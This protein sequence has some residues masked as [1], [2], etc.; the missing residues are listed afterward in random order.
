[1]PKHLVSE[2]RSRFASAI[3]QSP[4]AAL[5]LG[6]GIA[7]LAG[8]PARAQN[9]GKLAAVDI[10]EVLRESE[11][12]KAA[13]ARLEDAKKKKQTFLDSKQKELEDLQK[14]Y[15]TAPLS[16]TKRDELETKI[17]ALIKDVNRFKEDAR[18]ELEK[19]EEA[20]LKKLQE[21]VLPL[22]DEIGAKEG[23]A[24]IFVKYQ[25]GLIYLDSSLDLTKTLILRYDAARKAGTL[26]KPK[27]DADD[28]KGLA[29]KA[30]PKSK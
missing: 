16:D 17:Q 22:I 26:P 10:Q 29:P 28:G 19:A 6:L 14:Q 12:G 27:P 13:L 24:M 8:L 21:E 23:Y 9:A 18:L 4:R 7:L 11:A 15:N 3:A 30:D 1:M 5:A 2:P 20:E 25:S